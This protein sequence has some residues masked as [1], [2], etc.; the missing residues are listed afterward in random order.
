MKLILILLLV[1]TGCKKNP[2]D[3]VEPSIPRIGLN[4]YVAPNGYDDN[5]GT[6]EYPFAT[7]QKAFK[8]ALPGDS[9]LIRGG[10]YKTSRTVLL[11]NKKGSPKN[12]LAIQN[13]PGETPVLDCSEM[14]ISGIIQ[15]LA[16]S[17]VEYVSIKGLNIGNTKQNSD[18][19][20]TIGCVFS[21]CNH[22]IVENVISHD[23]G[24]P[25]FYFQENKNILVK[26]CDAFNNYDAN[27][28]GYPG[29][30]ADG[31]DI[32][33]SDRDVY[34]RMV[35]CR[36]WNNSDDGFDFYNNEGTVI[37]DSCWSFGN[38]YDG[39]D[40]SGF[41]LGKTSL[42]ALDSQQRVIRNCIAAD[43]KSYGFD[44]NDANVRMHIYNNSSYGNLY[45]FGNYEYD[46]SK[47]VVVYRNNMSFLNSE[48]PNIFREEVVHDHNSWDIPSLLPI[49]N[50]D[51]LSIEVLQLTDDRQGDGSLP[52]ISFLRLAAGSK[53]IDM[54]T[55]V[56]IPYSG[57]A[58][59]LGAF[60]GTFLK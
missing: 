18:G 41:K 4:Y 49:T 52:S 13:Y 12:Y 6:L 5:N 51:F 30:H 27:T 16:V 36:A 31:F 15:G 14:N 7:W 60:E 38:G 11:T 26:N 32:I 1:H 21:N 28:K 40:G 58:P 8:V 19:S 53:L 37:V 45:G 56:G 3:P 20:K 46:G 39:G 44:E 42:S 9:I 22:L 34:A 25:G 17:N 50:D 48:G 54:G 59:D 57:E 43:N 24:G 10:V 55:E 33:G 29:G 47:E 35:G 2:F 23:H